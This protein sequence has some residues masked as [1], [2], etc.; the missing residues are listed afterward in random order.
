MEKIKQIELII[1]SLFLV[2][3][4][5]LILLF[6]SLDNST[7]RI[8]YSSNEVFIQTI[9]YPSKITK[10]E[11]IKVPY[12]FYTKVSESVQTS[13]FSSKKLSYSDFSNSYVKEGMFDEEIQVYEVKLENTGCKGGYFTVIFHF[14]TLCG[15]EKEES[16]R[17]YI[18]YNK[19]VNFVYKNIKG[20]R[21]K[22][23]SWS[24]EVV[25]ETETCS[26]YF[27]YTSSKERLVKEVRYKDEVLCTK[28]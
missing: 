27:E 5:I 18:L 2:S 4:F 12:E 6:L 11:V 13:I 24:Y 9:N 14:K 28:I 20:D 1:A 10:C 15:E 7:S 25:S 26:N 19:E 21:D 16:I 3:I 23:S 17:K 8:N 22:I